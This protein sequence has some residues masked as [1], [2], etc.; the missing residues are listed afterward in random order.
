MLID[1][2]LPAYQFSEF[3]SIEADGFAGNIY[4]EMFQCNFSDSSFIPLL[5]R[6][7][8]IKKE[9]GLIA[10]LTNMG[11]IKVDEQP[12]KEILFGMVT[13]YAMFKTCQSIFSS[14]EF[15]CQSE[16]TIIKA[17]IN[18]KLQAKSNSMHIIST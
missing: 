4:Q 2:Y 6:L 11:F 16:A 5:L 10:Q 3:H 15:V 9:V 13:D 8:G 12:G 14:K 17:V 1:K 7:R 18:F